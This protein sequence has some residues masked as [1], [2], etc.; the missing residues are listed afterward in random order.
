MI[1]RELGSSRVE[2]SIMLKILLD[3]LIFLGRIVCYFRY[4]CLVDHAVLLFVN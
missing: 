1:L 2:D 4:L 3:I